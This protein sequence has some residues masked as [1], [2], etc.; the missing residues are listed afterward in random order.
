MY[1]SPTL[2]H[3]ELVDLARSTLDAAFDH[4]PIRVGA[5][6]LQLLVALTD[7]VVAERPAFLRLAPGDAR[8]LERGQQRLVDLLGLL[9]D[10]AAEDTEGC[11][12]DRI[13]KDLVAELELQAA[14]ERRYLPAAVS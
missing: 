11:G 12:C 5:N 7:H 3:A 2:S 9:A 4:D 13:A 1:P 10:S 8:L 14:D 6:T